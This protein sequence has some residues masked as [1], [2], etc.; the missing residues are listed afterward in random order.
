M[1][2]DRYVTGRA[3]KTIR[4]VKLPTFY[5]EPAP[6]TDPETTEV[7]RLHAPLLAAAQRRRCFAEVELCPTEDAA[8]LEARRCLR[9]DLDF[10]QPH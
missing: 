9:C 1:M 10:T 2:I 6:Q 8:M 7:F 4:K 3:L 5:V